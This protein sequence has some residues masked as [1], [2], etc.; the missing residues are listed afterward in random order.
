MRGRMILI[1]IKTGIYFQ[2][3]LCTVLFQAADRQV[4]PDHVS[5][6][7]MT[8]CERA[9]PWLAYKLAR[10]ALRF[11]QCAIAE[12]LFNSLAQKVREH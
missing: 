12:Q 3:Y 1:Y 10:Q 9:N 6:Q 7:M 2:V 11:G 5:Q 4:I 8:V